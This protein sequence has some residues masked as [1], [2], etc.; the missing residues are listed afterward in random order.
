M[1]VA[2]LCDGRTLTRW[3]ARAIERIQDKHQ[4]YLLVAGNGAPARRRARHLLYYALNLVSVRNRL[5]RPV[6]FPTPDTPVAGR[7]AF[8]PGRDGDW[9]VIPDDALG[10][11][12][13]NGIEAVVKFGLGLLRVPP[14]E[15]LAAPI[16]SYHHGDP[17]A[18]RGRPAGFYEL[19][20]GEAVMG[21]VIQ[22]L[23]ARLDGGDVV[24][25]ADSRVVPHSYRA[26]LIEAYRLSPHL[27]PKALERVATGKV[28]EFQPT[29]RNYRLPGN[30]TV[31]KLVA[32]SAVRLLARAAYGLSIEK[33]WRVGLLV[34]ADSS[35]PIAAIRSADRAMA[36]W[37]VPPMDARHAFH[38]DPFFGASASE[39]MVEALNRTSGKGELAR[40]RG[41]RS[42]TI[43]VGPG[44]L[45]YPASFEEGGQ[46]YPVPEVCEWADPAAWRIDGD[47][48]EKVAKLDIDS[49]PLIDPTL[50]RHEGSVY[51][52]AN[53]LDEGDMVLHLWRAPSLFGRFDLHP[54]SPVRLSARGAR[55][56]GE[57]ARWDGALYR[58]G[59]DWR[60]G[61]GDGIVAFRIDELGPSTYRETEV[62]SASFT[63]VRG[64]HT[65]NH[66][67]S[68]LLFDFYEE[69]RSPLAGL[70]RVRAKL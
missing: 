35:H 8:D 21:Q 16:L 62:G 48:A 19:L 43:A 68:T 45:S 33:R 67:G 14:A 60:G 52:F 34:E 30:L 55:M 3:Q 17:R 61:Y 51:L 15:K 11:L 12:R 23:G 53:R 42:E 27:L 18:F 1:R 54:R 31:A 65:L 20:A 9:D 39:I 50:I 22:R 2:I 56:A 24:A 59:Q 26:T 4:L 13:E 29:G 32:R 69:R 37:T 46:S 28:L 10:W 44:H 47:R 40:I 57:I 38:A 7:F 49:G 6:A 63:G 58:L 36:G 64:P 25:F 5:T 66:R 41:G 70:R